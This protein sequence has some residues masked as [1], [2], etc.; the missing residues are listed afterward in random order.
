[1]GIFSDGMNDIYSYALLREV[2]LI[3]RDI[4]DKDGDKDDNER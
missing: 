4:E 2:A 1:M 3:T